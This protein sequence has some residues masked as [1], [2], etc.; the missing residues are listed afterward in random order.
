[1]AMYPYITLND[2]TEIVHSHLIKKDGMKI[3][4]VYFERPKMGGFDSARISLPTYT[5]I[6]R[7]GFS[8]DEIKEFE[9]FAARHAHNFYELAEIGGIDFA[10]AV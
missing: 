10:S 3:V 4:E 8:D 2:E 1:M 5:W 9:D 7:D 6:E